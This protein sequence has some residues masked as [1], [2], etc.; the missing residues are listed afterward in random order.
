MSDYEARIKT[1]LG[2]FIIHFTDNE[3]LKKKLLQIPEF[4]KTIEESIGSI[5]VKES[6]KVIQ[7]L[8]DI[9]TFGSDGMVRLLR[10]PKKKSELMKLAL[11]LSSAPLTPVQL[12][13]ITG[14][15]NP[16]AYMTTKDFIANADGTYTLSSETRAEVVN[17][18]IPSLRTSAPK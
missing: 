10:Y 7:G 18:L 1:N 17:E 5:L 15:H 8:E 14:E 16:A 13:N 6:E 4:K 9:Y 11:F 12:K 3:D 2:E